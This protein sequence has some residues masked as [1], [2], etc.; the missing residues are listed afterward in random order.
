MSSLGG[1]G[2]ERVTLNLALEFC[3]LGHQ[4][5]LLVASSKGPLRSEVPA[6][7]GFVDLSAS[8]NCSCDSA[9]RCIFAQ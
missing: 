2:A 9:S 4:V 5:D 6:S 8:Q 1:G 7:V 3:R